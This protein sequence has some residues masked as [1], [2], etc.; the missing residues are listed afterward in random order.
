MSREQELQ[1]MSQLSPNTQSSPLQLEDA[2]RAH[3][4]EPHD[5]H[6]QSDEARD[7]PVHQVFQDHRA[8]HV[9]QRSVQFQQHVHGP[10][11]SIVG[12]L[13]AQAASSE[14]RAEAASAVAGVRM[15]AAQAVVDARLSAEVSRREAVEAVAQAQMNAE[16]TRIGAVEQ[17]RS[18]EMQLEAARYENEMIKQQMNQVMEDSKRAG[19]HGAVNGAGFNLIFQRL[20]GI[21]MQLQRLETKMDTHQEYIQELWLHQPPIPQVQQE[22][23]QTPVVRLD[24]QDTQGGNEFQLFAD[25]REDRGSQ[26][27]SQMSVQELE[28]RCLRTKDLH[29][30]KLP[31]LPESASQFRSWK[32]SVRTMILSYD[33]SQ[34]GLV[35]QWLSP[36]FTARDAEADLLRT[37]SGD[38]PRLDRIMA[39][40]LCKQES[41]K[42]SFG[43]RIQ[44]YVESCESSGNQIRDVTSSTWFQGSLTHRPRPVQSPVRWS[45]SNYQH[46]RIHLRPSN[47][48]MT[49]LCTS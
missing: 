17:I 4:L 41:L 48:G 15:E 25:D 9:D 7:S 38:F 22:G 21:E 34:E 44:S 8:I 32:N 47:I 49:K 13:A 19:D 29:H 26:D 20:A 39:S 1:E 28:K 33:H 2:S 10:D 11:P 12:N 6:M 46:P 3:L 42:T 18:L 5:S 24:G 40:V 37:Q 23:G 31:Q 43:L 36:A 30:L 14:M 27:G 35:S 45:C 16:S